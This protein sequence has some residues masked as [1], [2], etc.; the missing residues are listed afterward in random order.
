MYVG[1][2]WASVS[3]AMKGRIITSL[4]P[5]LQVENMTGSSALTKKI[6]YTKRW[7]SFLL[8]LNHLI[9]DSLLVLVFL[10]ELCKTREINSIQIRQT[11][12]MES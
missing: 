3:I 4:L 5:I 9:L 12:F 11:P 8:L 1:L 6:C 2:S 10:K 7:Y